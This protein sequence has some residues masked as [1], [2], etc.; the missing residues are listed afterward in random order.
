LAVATAGVAAALVLP[1]SAL[2]HATLKSTSPSTQSRIDATPTEIVLR[3]DQAVG[4]IPHSLEVFAKDGR[5]ISGAAVFGADHRI[6]RAP[7]HGL[8]RGGYSVRWRVLSSDGHVGSG[9][10]TFGFQMAAPPP[11]E[12]YGASGPTWGDDVARWGLFASLALLLGSLGVRLLVLREPVPER[13]S[14][15]LYVFAGLGAFAV[16]DVGILAFILR[17]ENALQLPIADLMYGDLSPFA[18]KTRFGHAFVAMTLGFALGAAFVFLSWLLDRPRLLWAAFVIGLGFASGL[19]LSGH[20][21][22]EPNSSWLSQV[23]DFLHLTAASLWAGG[24]VC[25]ALAVW[26]LAPELRRMAF[27]GFS[28]LAT[29]LVG[30][31]VLAGTYLAI[32]RLPALHD[33]WSAGYGRI[34]LIKLA[35]VC[36]AL[37]WGAAHHFFVRPRLERSGAPRGLR[38]SLLG[39]MSVAMAVLLVA[40]I[41]VN[42]APPPRPDTTP[43]QAAPAGR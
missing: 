23:A 26:P 15:R 28:R 31:L 1:S 35:I 20:S 22:V 33:L 25:L 38:R 21:A 10:F 40:A 27:L 39:E 3:F 24:L 11:T 42:S 19:S 18:T 43:N 6:V 2:A 5:K 34:L 9:V 32:L 13:L 37:S 30:V 41:L 17:A 4:I 12:A 16:I 29:V 14:R 36:V 8:V 7:V